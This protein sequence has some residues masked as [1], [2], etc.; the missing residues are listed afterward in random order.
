EALAAV[1]PP[2]REK[3]TA[4]RLPIN[5]LTFV[6]D[7]RAIEFNDNDARWHCDLTAYTCKKADARGGGR[8]GRGGIPL[9]RGIPGPS[10]NF[11]QNQDAKVSPDGKWEAWVNNFNVWVRAKGKRDGAALSFDGSEGNYYAL[12]SL[13]WS[14]DSKMLAAYRVRP[15]YS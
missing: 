10:Y 8:G 9:S 1:M 5:E 15:G 13:V 14:P 3:I 12:A 7:E 6:D 11:M 2:G 4:L